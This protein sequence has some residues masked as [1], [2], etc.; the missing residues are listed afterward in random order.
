MLS[1]SGRESQMEIDLGVIGRG[2]G[3]AGVPCSD[4]L[5]QFAS[6]AARLDGDP[7]GVVAMNEA[8]QRLVAVAGEAT[9]IDAAAVAANF[10][11]MTRLADGT[12]ARLP[13]ARLEAT[14]PAI[15]VIGAEAMASR[16]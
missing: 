3:D 12:G 15:A 16:R 1:W 4:E 5:L 6:A 8:R 7:S 14:A 2:S 10:Q 13:P 11:M 9:M